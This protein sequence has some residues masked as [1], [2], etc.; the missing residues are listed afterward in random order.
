MCCDVHPFILSNCH[1]YFVRD[2]HCNDSSKNGI[3]YIY[4]IVISVSNDDNKEFSFYVIYVLAI[5]N[6][7]LF[8]EKVISN[9]ANSALYASY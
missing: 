4:I 7:K 2:C 1:L 5:A 3:V 9:S 8:S 6:I